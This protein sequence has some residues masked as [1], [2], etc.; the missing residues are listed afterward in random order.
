MATIYFEDLT[1]GSV[2][3][4]D[5][6]V[7]DKNEMIEYARKNDPWPIHVDEQAANGTPYRGLIASGGHS[8]SLYYRLGHPL[9]NNADTQWAFLG[10]F[11]WHVTFGHP[12]RP[13]DRLRR[14]LEIRD[15]RLSSKPGRGIVNSVGSLVNQNSEEALKIEVAFMIATR[16]PRGG[17]ESNG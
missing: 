4:G 10:G 9:Y 13:G 2:F 12:V 14:K 15:Q 7:V 1:V 8:I 6:Y 17:G 16:P 11:D 3:W 5:E